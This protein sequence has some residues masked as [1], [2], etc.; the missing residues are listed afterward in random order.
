MLNPAKSLFEM[1]AEMDSEM[2]PMLLKMAKALA[3]RMAFKHVEATA[4]SPEEEE[5]NNWAITMAHLISDA[6][7][8]EGIMRTAMLDAINLQQKQR[9]L[10]EKPYEVPKVS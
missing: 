3:Q 1:N 9:N 8:P 5:S 7:T 2:K 4:S 6:S 10:L